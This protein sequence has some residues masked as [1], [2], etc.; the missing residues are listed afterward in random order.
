MHAMNLH[1]NW[2]T[3]LVALPFVIMTMVG[4]FRLDEVFA[5][6]RN[7]KLP[8]RRSRTGTD[9]RLWKPIRKTR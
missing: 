1:S 5:P 3:M 2:D 4:M 7:G 9:A 6:P 8:P